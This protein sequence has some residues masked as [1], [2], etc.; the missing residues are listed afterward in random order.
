MYQEFE[1]K[2]GLFQA[3]LQSFLDNMNCL[4]F[5]DLKDTPQGLSSIYAFYERLLALMASGEK[6]KGCL[7]L[8]TAIDSPCRDHNIVEMVQRQYKKAQDLFRAN[9]DIAKTQ[10]DID[11]DT[12]TNAIALYLVGINHALSVMHRLD[13]PIAEIEKFL[14]TA[15]KTI[16]PIVTA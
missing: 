7:V 16:N 1:S 5:G 13:T 6:M 14:N 15:L 11:S 12:D 4:L 9:L 2:E 10:G 8:N 3:S